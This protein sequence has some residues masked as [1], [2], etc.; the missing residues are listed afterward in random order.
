MGIEIIILLV[1]SLRQSN[2]LL[3]I[4]SL[5]H[6]A[7]IMFTLDHIHYSRWM[8]V[9][10]QDLLLLP[11]KN[12]KLFTEFLSGS[13]VVNKS[14]G[15]FNSMAYDQAHEQNN[16]TVKSKNRSIDLLNKEDRGD[17]KKL[18]LALPEIFE[19][20]ELVE[21]PDI[22]ESHK[23]QSP[24]FILKFVKDIQAVTSGFKNNPFTKE[25]FKPIN[26]TGFVF[27]EA[28]VND[29]DRMFELGAK[30]HEQFVE[31][32]LQKGSLMVVDTKISKN[33]FKLPSS[34][35][36]LKADTDQ[37]K[38]NQSTLTKLDSACQHRRAAALKLFK[39]EF[40]G[41]P[42]CF[43]KDGIPFHGT[44]SDI[45]KSILPTSCNGDPSVSTDDQDG[46][47]FDVYI[48]DLSV[49]IRAK[50]S[51]RDSLDKEMTCSQFC[52][53]ILNGA[54]NFAKSVGAKRLY[55]VA[56]MYRINYIKGPTWK[57]GAGERVQE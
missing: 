2:L 45:L 39:T 19:Y 24:N 9:F 36:A 56:D 40:T 5:Q 48:V 30:K 29:V 16:L 47:S 15:L 57:K 4:A 54:C 51:V 46:E 21:G 42:E 53:S 6:L 52:L 55:L 3:F 23:E 31:T 32:R 10:I 49:Q 12:H 1:R 18:E 44:K 26:S 41:V 22:A 50:A 27:P 7:P 8:S 20:L 25:Q 33:L 34:A 37:I 14:H 38:L 13:F 35:S 43:V 11:K 28:I 17:L